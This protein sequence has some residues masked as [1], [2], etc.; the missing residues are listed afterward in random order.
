MG[1]V[2]GGVIKF[3][4]D[5]CNISGRGDVAG[6]ELVVPLQGEAEIELAATV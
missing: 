5:I 1:A 4:V 6:L 2:S 3:L